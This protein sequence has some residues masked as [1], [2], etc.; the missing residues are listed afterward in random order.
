MKEKGGIIVNVS[1][2]AGF[3]GVF[4][5]SA[6]GVSKYGI[7]GISEVL[8]SELKRYNIHVSVLCPPDTDTPQFAEEEK[9]KPPETKAIAGTA[10]LMTPEAV[11]KS[12]IKGIE[13]KK[14]MIIPGFSGKF[15]YFMKRHLPGFVQFVF[16]KDVKKV[17]K[18]SVFKA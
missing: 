17:Q 16:D 14:F 4:G 7:I 2:I 1:S 10:K 8:Y 5:Y 13:R 12:L 9:T 15:I 18:K 11:A 3:I 6:Y